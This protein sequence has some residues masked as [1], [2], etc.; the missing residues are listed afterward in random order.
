[1]KTPAQAAE[2][3]WAADRE[4]QADALIELKAFLLLQLA[5]PVIATAPNDPVVIAHVVRINSWIAALE[6]KGA[7]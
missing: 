1:M 2:F 3:A 7:P 6:S 5:N 4:S